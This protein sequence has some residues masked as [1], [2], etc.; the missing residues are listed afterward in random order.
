M[1][2]AARRCGSRRPL[3]IPETLLTSCVVSTPDRTSPIAALGLPP[4]HATRLV[5]APE[6]A[7]P[8]PAVATPADHHLTAA[9]R[10]EEKS[11]VR[12]NRNT[13]RAGA[14]RAGGGRADFSTESRIRNRPPTRGPRGVMTSRAP[15]RTC[16]RGPSTRRGD[17]AGA[18]EPETR[19]N[20]TEQAD[21]DPPSISVGNQ[22]QAS[23]E[24]D[25]EGPN[26]RNCTETNRRQQ[27]PGSNT[28]SWR[29]THSAKATAAL[30]VS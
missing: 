12:P 20:Q 21:P 5:G 2:Y 4:A 28:A 10:A 6:R 22:R 3:A 14:L 19:E 9:P 30:L 8:L 1:R 18:G 15:S 27:L 7:V 16:E 29:F 17:R 26:R 23:E 13:L 25:T 11:A 24:P